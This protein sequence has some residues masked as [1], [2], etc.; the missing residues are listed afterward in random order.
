M[1]LRGDLWFQGFMFNSLNQFELIFV[2]CV[3]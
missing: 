2:S 1:F 3:K